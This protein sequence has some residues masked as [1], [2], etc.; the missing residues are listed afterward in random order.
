MKP[1]E[2]IKIVHNSNNIQ[3]WFTSEAA[4]LF[5]WIDEIQQEN[6][7]IGDIFEIGCHHGKSTLFLCEMLDPSREKLGVCDLFGEQDA[8]ISC[9]GM[10]D[11]ETFKRNISS[12]SEGRMEIRIFQKNSISLTPKDVGDGIR[13]F[14]ID[15]GHT[16]YETL[17][18]LRLAS[19]AIIENGIIALDD[20]FRPEWPGVTEGLINFLDDYKQF[21]SIIVGFNKLILTKRSCSDLYFDAIRNVEQRQAY[22][23]DYPW[24]LKELDFKGNHLQIFYLPTHL[25]KTNLSIFLRK[26]YRKHNW[27][28]NPLFHP[29][30]TVANSIFRKSQQ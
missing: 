11:L 30:I 24:Q 26:Y 15:G 18:D 10:G 27:I 16:P 17:S 8:N 6:R 20:P 23:L 2:A 21:C 28:K 14:H 22:G 19:D 3:G 9:S 7:I 12:L 4:M 25:S 5:A 29:F 1:D 13:F